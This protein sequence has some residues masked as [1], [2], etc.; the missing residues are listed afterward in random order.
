M[1]W[2]VLITLFFV[3]NAVIGQGLSVN[4]ASGLVSIIDSVELKSKSLQEVKELMTKWAYTLIDEENLK[5]IYK[6]NN[7]KQTEKVAI[8]LPLWSVLTKDMG[9]NRFLTS[10]TLT[11]SRTKTNGL[12]AF[13]PTVTFGGIK[14]NLVYNVTPQKLIYEFTNLEYSHD[15]IHY[16]KFEDDKPPQDNYN[17]SILLSTSKKEWKN[18]RMEYFGNLKILADNLKEYTAKLLQGNSKPDNL[19][20]INYNSYQAIKLNMTYNEVKAILGGDGKELSNSSSQVNGK[21]ITL[22]TIVWY[23][24]D[25]SKSINISFSDG[26]VNGKSQTNL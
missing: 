11:Y 23:D 21:T 24:L 7:S 20:P 2:K 12:N 3:T 10:G 8:N 5:K 13:A 1:K 22:L 14:F 19:S 17:K 15:M 16:G 9:G 18:V 26:K 6:L 25:R 4:P